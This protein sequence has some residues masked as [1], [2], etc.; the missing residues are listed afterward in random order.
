M[1]TAPAG[2]HFG[3]VTKKPADSYSIG[4][5]VIVEFVGASPRNDLLLEDS[6]LA[7]QLLE[8]NEWTTI[9]DDS[10]WETKYKWRRVGVSESSV[11]VEWKIP[12]GT[13]PGTYRITTK[14]AYK[15]VWIKHYHG[16]TTP[17]SVTA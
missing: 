15:M 4:Q 13:V 2:K 12:V 7:I 1:D 9:C 6:Y 3:D 8:S 11:T 16:E 17:F 5:T 10:C 14:G